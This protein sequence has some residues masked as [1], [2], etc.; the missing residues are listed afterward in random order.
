M[1]GLVGYLDKKAKA[2]GERSSFLGT[3]YR[4]VSIESEK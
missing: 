1:S 2:E 3:L 4:Y